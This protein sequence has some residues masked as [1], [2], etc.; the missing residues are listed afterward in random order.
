MTE[1]VVKGQCKSSLRQGTDAFLNATFPLWGLAFP[2]ASIIAFIIFLVSF[3][4][5]HWTWDYF[6]GKSVFEPFA[7]ISI[8]ALSSVICLLMKRALAND[9]LV[10]DKDGIKLPR[11][12]GNSI[13]FKNYIPWSSLASVQA[14]VSKTELAKCKIT[15]FKKR[16]RPIQLQAKNLDATLVE[17]IALA[18]QMWAP[19]LYDTTLEEL[20]EAIRIGAREESQTS[21]TS[22]WEDE[23]SRRF[24]PAS[25]VPLEPGKVLR[26]STLKVV[27]HL[28]SGGLSALYLCQLD[29]KGLVVL[30]EAAI[31]EDSA[32]NVREKAH[33]LFDR[34]AQLLMKLEHPSIVHVLDC[35]SENGRDYLL[36]E[37]I[38]GLDL[39]QMVK[40]N[41]PQPESEVLDWAIQVA[42][43]LKYLHERDIPI[44]HRDLT[45]DNLVLRNDGKVFIVDF[46]AA[47]EFIGNATGTFVGK[48]SYIAPEQ[49]RGKATVHSDIYAFGCT[50]YY[51]LTGSEPEALMVSDP[52]E[53]APTVS[54]ELAEVVQ[55]C[56]QMEARDRYQ[57]VA[58]LIP[59][60]RR[61][62][63]Q[64][65]AI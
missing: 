26:N 60:L 20:Q 2:I 1:L 45:P 29:G 41:G 11:M 53:L 4:Y 57:S 38:N 58:Q 25:Y 50:L 49:L 39:H 46:G 37:Y 30:K 48:H 61:L 27:S 9:Y 56:T 8:C 21:Y 32:E 63:A 47:N 24:C 5:I 22:L 42:N 13:W 55:S 54:P 34:E 59:V 44:L 14:S 7:F 35:F 10:I 18:T 65:V 23:L 31:P 17:Q 28:A 40:Q 51:L 62:A 3:S 16:G 15:L 43:A 64:S 52:R 33:E 19:H 12:I 36:I 6:L